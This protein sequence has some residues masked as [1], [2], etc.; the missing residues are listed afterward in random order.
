MP[1]P[2]TLK[3]RLMSLDY[4]QAYCEASETH[5]TSRQARKLDDRVAATSA[6]NV[7]PIPHG[8]FSPDTYERQ[9]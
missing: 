4:N 3:V 5:M 2:A 6:N 9:P 7:L 1:P 8:H